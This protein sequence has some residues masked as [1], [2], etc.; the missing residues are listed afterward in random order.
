[1]NDKKSIRISAKNLGGLALPDCCQ[2]CFYIKLKLNNKLPWT[3][4]PGIFS[5]IDSYSK[6]ITWQYFDKHRRVPS[7]FDPYGEF[8]GLLP[9]PGWSKFS[10][11]DKQFNIR[12]TGVPDD[13]FIMKD[14]RY[15]I[16]DYKT[17]KYTGNQDRLL[18]MYRVQL[19]GYALIFERLGMGKVGGL[20]LCYYEP[21][22]NVGAENIDTMMQDN[23]FVMPFTAYLKRIELE[24]ERVV[25]P[26]LRKVRE[27]VGRG[28]VPEGREGCEDCGKLGDVV[29]LL[30]RMEEK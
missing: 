9:A 17:A 11:V 24:P 3:I 28:V 23:G 16:V 1:M 20:G 2:R 7:W 6:K 14:G 22:N 15:F 10:I 13:I 4:F 25:N 30:G 5:T 26:L 27:M 8:R 21:Q 18:P 12:V 29:E 19:N